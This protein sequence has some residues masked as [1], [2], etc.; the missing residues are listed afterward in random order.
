MWSSLR[1]IVRQT[2]TNSKRRRLN[3]NKNTRK[4]RWL[5]IACTQCYMH[6]IVFLFIHTMTV[7]YD[8]SKENFMMIVSMNG[9][10]YMP[11]VYRAC[12]I[13]RAQPWN[14]CTK[15]FSERQKAR[16]RRGIAPQMIYE[17]ASIHSSRASQ[18][19]TMVAPC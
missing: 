10:G 17:E 3:Y 18:K 14:T 9:E 13:I 1:T 7:C 5:H 2:S 8:I 6:E 15:R 4:E 16:K 19:T 11:L 12:C